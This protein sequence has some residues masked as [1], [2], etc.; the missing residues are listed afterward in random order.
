MIDLIY[1]SINLGMGWSPGYTV[2][3]VMINF[4]AFMADM[5]SQ[6]GQWG[7]ATFQVNPKVLKCNPD[8]SANLIHSILYHFFLSIYINRITRSWHRTLL[9]KT[10]DTLLRN[11]TLQC[12]TCP[13]NLQKVID[14]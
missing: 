7:K 12:L 9:V 1:T 6:M 13:S 8:C 11:P 10:V 2:Q 14:Q 4:V 3:T 5:Q